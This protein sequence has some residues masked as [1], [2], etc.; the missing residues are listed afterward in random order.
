MKTKKWDLQAEQLKPPTANSLMGGCIPLIFSIKSF[1][2][3]KPSTTA[4]S[5]DLKNHLSWKVF[6][7][8]TLGLA[9]DLFLTLLH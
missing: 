5:F 4:W 6:A 1:C 3:S 7:L 8:L 2:A 9:W